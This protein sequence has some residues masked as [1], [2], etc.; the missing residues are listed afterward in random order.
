MGRG[1]HRARRHGP[2]ARRV[3]GPPAAAG[4]RHHRVVGGRGHRRPRHA[5]DGGAAHAAR[6]L[7]A[8]L[9]GRPGERVHPP[10]Q[11]D[12]AARALAPARLARRRAARGA[13]SSSRR[14]A[15]RTCSSAS[16]PSSS[17]PPPGGTAARPPRRE[18]PTP[19]RRPTAR[20]ARSGQRSAPWRRDP[21]TRTGGTGGRCAG[22]LRGA[23]R[24]SLTVQPPSTAMTWPVTWRLSSLH[25]QAMVPARSSGS[26][27]PRASG[28]RRSA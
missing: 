19:E 11:R 26:R 25:S 27:K 4:P 16:A 21:L 14:S 10:V 20:P 6:R 28:C 15:G 3:D 23:Q 22:G 12:R 5:H 17:R 9:R 24:A 2:G 7:P 13:R 8:G 18:P 1:D